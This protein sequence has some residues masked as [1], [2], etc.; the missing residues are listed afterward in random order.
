MDSIG[1]S[2]YVACLLREH[3]K[4][5]AARLYFTSAVHQAMRLTNILPARVEIRKV[6]GFFDIN[7]DIHT[8]VRWGAFFI[9]VLHRV[10][11]KRAEGIF[12]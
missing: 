11:K 4:K 5:K 10:L 6:C 9:P 1:A 2:L 12:E 3:G 8:L 7:H